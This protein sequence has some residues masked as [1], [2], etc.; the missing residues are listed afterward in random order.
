M[1]SVATTLSFK[2]S[3]LGVVHVRTVWLTRLPH[4][5]Q[6]SALVVSLSRVGTPASL[7]WSFPSDQRRHGSNTGVVLSQRAATK[8]ALVGTLIAREHSLLL[9]S[10]DAWE[11]PPVA[12]KECER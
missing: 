5:E 7:G 10:L 12:V 2:N 6:G 1:H 4:C 11:L 9:G 8:T 3:P